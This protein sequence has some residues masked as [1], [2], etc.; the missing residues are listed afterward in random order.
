MILYYF[1]QFM[2]SSKTNNLPSS[3]DDKLLLADNHRH[4]NPKNPTQ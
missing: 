4:L 2:R 3:Q 1:Y